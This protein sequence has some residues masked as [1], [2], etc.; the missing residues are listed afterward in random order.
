MTPAE[1]WNWYAREYHA[2]VYYHGYEQ[3]ARV[4]NLRLDAYA[5]PEGAA[6]LDVGSG[7]N[8][9]IHRARERGIHA[10]GVEPGDQAAGPLTYSKPLR[11]CHFP[12]GHFDVVTIH[13]VLEHMPDPRGEL[14]E[15]ARILKP[16]GRFLLDW[17]RFHAPN[18]AGRHHWKPVE[19]LWML[20][21]DQVVD[22]LA[23]EGFA[24][25]RLDHPR[26]SRSVFYT[27]NRAK[28]SDVRIL[29]P[30]GIGDGYWVAAKLRAFLD[31]R[32]IVLPQIWAHSAGP[33][34]SGD[35]WRSL[36]FVRFMGFAPLPKGPFA[37][38]AF[39]MPDYPIQTDVP[40]FDYFVSL[41]GALEGGRTLDQALP[42][43]TE[44]VLPRFQSK[45]EDAR[46]EEF[47]KQFGPYVAVA[48]WDQ[49]F[50]SKWLRQFSLTSIVDSLQQIT[51]AGY[52]VVV[53][54]AAWD[55]AGIS[56]RI[57][58]AD[59]KGRFASLVG[60]TS[61]EDL[62]ALVRGSAGVYGFPAGNTLL[63]AFLGRPTTLIW[64]AHFRR[65]FW[66]NVCPPDARH[67]QPIGS[68]TSSRRAASL[69]V[70]LIRKYERR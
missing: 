4:A 66:V 47:R 70:S 42:G 10:Y 67:Y 36:P 28:V 38:R 60:E 45:A 51:E 30:A 26:E 16:G 43:P 27:T 13:D 46:V 61:Y 49:G 41:N 50:Y 3:D 53:M 69:V 40:G 55:R 35:F 5:I 12:T 68:V 44:W 8:A 52:R 39:A 33:N 31:Q 20:T 23:A 29:V 15:I 63:G 32:G 48:F 2:G 7:N 9:F 65:E 54:G 22:L 57:I 11:E 64:N 18:D 34:R 17:P 62:V 58:K 24:V 1:Y 25:D 14:R 6:L 56:A 21:D 59:R 19:H 37:T